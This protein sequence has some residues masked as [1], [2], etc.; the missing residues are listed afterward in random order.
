MAQP[1]SS[2]SKKSAEELKDEKA[3]KEN[4]QLLL[5]LGI[6]EMVHDLDLLHA[7]EAPPTELKSEDKK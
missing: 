1:K 5:R 4:Y 3:M 2:K 6:V 7:P